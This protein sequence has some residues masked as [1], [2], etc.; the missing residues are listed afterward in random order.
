MPDIINK[1][2]IA[3]RD[4][5]G[6]FKCFLNPNKPQ[7]G[8]YLYLNNPDGLKQPEQRMFRTYEAWA[9]L[10]TP[11]VIGVGIII[12]LCVI[13]LQIQLESDDTKTTKHDFGEILSTTLYFWFYNLQ[14]SLNLKNIGMNQKSAVISPTC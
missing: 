7:N 12:Y 4:N 2:R 10:V 6:T 8:A 9:M 1:T 5:S 11:S 3:E 14:S 13:F